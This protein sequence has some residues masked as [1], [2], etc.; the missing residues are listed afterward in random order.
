MFTITIAL[1]IFEA[2]VY[3]AVDERWRRNRTF[4]LRFVIVISPNGLVDIR[5]GI[6]ENI[7]RLSQ[8]DV[9][10]ISGIADVDNMLPDSGLALG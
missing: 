4:A 2:G 3:C 7:V 5:G 8:R 9:D 6:F 1:S 10:N